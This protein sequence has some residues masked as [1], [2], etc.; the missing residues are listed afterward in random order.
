MDSLLAAAGAAYN[1]VETSRIVAGPGTQALIQWLPQLAAPGPVTIIGPTYAEHGESWR[2]AGFALREVGRAADVGDA[3]HLVVVNPNNPDGRILSRPELLALAGHCAERGGWLIVDESFA[4]LDPSCSIAD[5]IGD[6]P[7]IVLR[8]FGKF[9]GLA[10]L[11]LGFA[12]A[13]PDLAATLAAA[14]GPWAVS[15]PAIAIGSEALRD[16]DWAWSMRERLGDEAGALDDV[17]RRAGLEVLGGTT[18]YRLARYQAAGLIH[19]RLAAKHVWVRRFAWQDD[20]L[21]FGLPPD[22]AGLARLATA[23]LRAVAGDESGLR[24]G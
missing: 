1:V 9:Y 21:R 5:A 16:A 11:R 17:L 4:D 23:L 6:L 8:S 7:A 20:L 14:L 22:A 13:R 3:R 18:L 19:E 12:I 15:A 24:P 2:R 10:G